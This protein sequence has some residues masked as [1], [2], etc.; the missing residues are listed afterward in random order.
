[1]VLSNDYRVNGYSLHINIARFEPIQVFFMELL[2]YTIQKTVKTEYS[3]L[4]LRM[5]FHFLN[6]MKK[7]NFLEFYLLNSTEDLQIPFT[8]C[9]QLFDRRLTVRP[10][11][12]TK[13]IKIFEDVCLSKF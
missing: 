10:I 6:N 1:M 12:D 8:I 9:L 2:A 13:M 3:I 11:F 5:T 4:A 7:V